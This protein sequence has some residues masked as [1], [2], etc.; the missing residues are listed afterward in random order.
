M[1]DHK[2]RVR[3]VGGFVCVLS[4]LEKVDRFYQCLG[5]DEGE[6]CIIEHYAY[7]RPMSRLISLYWRLS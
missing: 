2:F 5:F 1:I 4:V 6:G 7:R 3:F